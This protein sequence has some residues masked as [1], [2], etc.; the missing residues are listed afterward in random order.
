MTTH[1][2]TSSNNQ[3]NRGHISLGNITP[4]N[5]PSEKI[6][7][8]LL[9]FSIRDPIS[10]DMIHPRHLK[11]PDDWI[12]FIYYATSSPNRDAIGYH[13]RQ[14]LIKFLASCNIDDI[15]RGEAI[16]LTRISRPRPDQI[17]N[18]RPLFE[19]IRI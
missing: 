8:A 13:A 10:F 11:T 3:H 14:E 2:I 15:S 4:H 6:L 12:R 1:D 9:I 19:R 18:L 7:N 5:P 17:P 16:I